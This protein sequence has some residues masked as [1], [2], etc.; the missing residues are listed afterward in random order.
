[1]I[2]ML[3]DFAKSFQILLVSQLAFVRLGSLLI[4]GIYLINDQIDDFQREIVKSLHVSEP[5]DKSLWRELTRE[6][7]LR[8]A[9]CGAPIC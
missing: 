8:G 7:Y 1:M 9:L 5:S 6:S 3:R 2:Q 4:E